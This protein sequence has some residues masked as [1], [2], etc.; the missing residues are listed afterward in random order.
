MLA[1][2][3]RR[4][5]SARMPARPWIGTRA[6]AAGRW[7]QPGRQQQQQRQQ[8][9]QYSTKQ[10][11]E[12]AQSSS[13]EKAEAGRG[14]RNTLRA[15]R[16]RPASHITA[17][18]VLHEITAVAPLGGVYWVLSYL[19][20]RIPVPES[21]LHEGNRYINRLRS[22]GGWTTPLAPDS[23]VLLDLATSYAVVKAAAPL[24]L[25]LSLAL[26]P[27]FANRAVVPLARALGSL[28]SA[29]KKKK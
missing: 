19:E 20:L 15:L 18:A 7:K 29:W 6:R 4:M 10:P 22:Y 1:L 28:R 17:F 11:P 24:R 13:K 27:W 12:S 8:R 3:Y 9:Q 2:E 5:L 23:P 14:W 26:T 21:V 16:D 25:A